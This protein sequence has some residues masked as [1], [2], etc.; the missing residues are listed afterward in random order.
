MESYHY[1]C[2][3]PLTGVPETYIDEFGCKPGRTGG[4]GRSCPAV[5]RLGGPLECTQLASGRGIS[6]AGFDNIGLGMLTV[7]QCTTTAGW[8]QVM[9][10]VMDSGAEVA[11]PYFVLLIFFGPYFV[12]NLFLAVLKTKFGKAQ[13]LFLANMVVTQDKKQN[14]LAAAAG[15][16]LRVLGG[17]VERRRVAAQ[18]REEDLA[19]KLQESDGAWSWRVEYKR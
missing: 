7:F 11:V 10:R 14:T 8:A 16:V 13:S 2:Q 6:V 1:R 17:C 19:R 15:W 5:G 12:V 18:A 3:N 9:Y 4:I